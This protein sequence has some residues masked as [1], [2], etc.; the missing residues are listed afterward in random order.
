VL[1]CDRG[2]EP[3]SWKGLISRVAAAWVWAVFLLINLFGESVGPVIGIEH[4]LADLVIPFHHAPKVLTGAPFEPG[5][6][7]IMVVMMLII[8]AVGLLGLRRRDLR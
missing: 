2:C 1:G 8:S 7:V 3:E 6:I 4:A 5:P